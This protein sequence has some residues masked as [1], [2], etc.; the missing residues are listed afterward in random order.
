MTCP[1]G[2]PSISGKEPATIPI[3][4]AAAVLQARD[5]RTAAAAA[6][7]QVRRA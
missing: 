4:V 1:I 7:A 2:V 5:R 6:P 3:A